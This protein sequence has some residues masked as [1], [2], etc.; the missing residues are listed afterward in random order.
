[1]TGAYTG[2][3]A[4]T[5]SGPLHFGS[6]VTA[7]ASFLDARSRGGRW[8]VRIDDLDTQRVR[9][10]A[11]DKILRT[12]DYLGLEW[13][14]ALVYQSDRIDAYLEALT[15]LKEKG[16]LYRCY[17]RRQETRGI[18]YPGTCRHR[19]TATRTQYAYR[20]ITNTEETGFIDRIQG[21]FSR[22]INHE[23]GD[24]IVQRSDRIPAYH[25]ATVVDDS[26]QG[27]TTVMRGA[28]LLESTSTQIYL[29]RHLSCPM[30]EYAHIPVAI[31]ADGKKISK[32]DEEI[33]PVME[34]SPATILVAALHFLGQPVKPGLIKAGVRDVTA[35]GL[36]N[37]DVSLIPRV[38]EI[39]AGTED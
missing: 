13:D 23:T 19:N 18:R 20:I 9:P 15:A 39:Q 36:E 32:Q 8:L 4:P 26:W 24:F 28:D 38:R 1:M 25:L 2:R 3:F 5:P 14:Q 7:L 10:G 22:N 17:C 29:Q 11:S 21:Y 30:P 33:H 6:I 34:K 35:W 12:L 37:W 16:L 31:A 27:V